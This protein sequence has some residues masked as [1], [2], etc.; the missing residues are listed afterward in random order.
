MAHQTVQAASS[1]AWSL[2]RRQ[3]DVIA[4]EQLLALGFSSDA[5]KHRV[6]RGRLH[7]VHRGVYAVGRPQLSR[8]GEWMAAVLACGPGAALSHASAAALWEI[9]P[10]RRGPLHV[11][12]PVATYPRRPGIAVHRRIA[13]AE[14]DLTRRH[15][16]PV[17]TP[18]CTLVDLAARAA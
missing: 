14:S 13:L 18:L 12:V 16:I 2:A 3:H 9:R 11:S 7:P 15:G 4:R 6:L 10:D 17:T 5:I 1:A 8:L